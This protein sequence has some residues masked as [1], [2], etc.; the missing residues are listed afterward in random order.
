MLSQVSVCSEG[1][2]VVRSNASWDR[3][4]GRHPLWE[5][6]RWEPLPGK[7]QVE[8]PSLDVRPGTP[9]LVTSGGDHW[10][11]VQTCSFGDPRQWHLMVANVTEAHTLSKQVVCNHWNAFLLNFCLYTWYIKLVGLK[12]HRHV[13]VHG[14]SLSLHVYP[15]FCASKHFRCDSTVSMTSNSSKQ[16]HIQ[17][18]IHVVNYYAKLSLLR[19]FNL[20]SIRTLHYLKN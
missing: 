5:K 16:N 19:Q 1:G 12:Y 10:I 13:I 6:V 2:G 3:S 14:D 7:V 9:L 18:I 20:E 11:P 17:N 8:Y 15:K 4:H